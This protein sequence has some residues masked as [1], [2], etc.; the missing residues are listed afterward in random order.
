VTARPD[1]LSL[2]VLAAG[3]GSRFGGLKQLAAV[4]SDGATIMDFNIRR[5]AAAGF[6][7]AVL[8]IAPGMEGQMRR[9]LVEE[10]GVPPIPVDVVVQ[11]VVPGRSRPLGT[12]A[13]VLAA[14]DA[15]AGSFVVVNGDDVYPTS[16]FA[17]IEEHLHRGSGAEHA[18]VAFRA[19]QTLVS[20]RPVSRAALDIDAA[21]ALVAIREG[22]ITAGAAGLEFAVAG[23]VR[24]LGSDAR[25]SMNMWGFRPSIFEPLAAAVAEF[26][27][28]DRD[29]EVW[30]PDVVQAQVDAGVTV[31]VLVCEERCFGVTHPDDVGPVRSMLS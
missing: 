1:G 11:P 6:S 9:H 8:V 16:A 7:R 5:A 18:L 19:A 2:V 25:V 3:L 31:R 22:T 4:G 29:G 13:A 23:A 26:V 24:P 12:A 10:P 15:V 14:R 17:L 30:L 28:E 20:D 27:A 21:G